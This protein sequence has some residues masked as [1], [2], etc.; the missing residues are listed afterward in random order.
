MSRTKRRIESDHI[1]RS[2]LKD[3]LFI[4]LED[5]LIIFGNA[6]GRLLRLRRQADSRND[7]Q[8]Y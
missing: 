3:G 1:F 5:F 6:I 2:P 7:N 8:L 4:W